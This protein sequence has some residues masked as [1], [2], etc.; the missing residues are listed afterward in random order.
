MNYFPRLDRWF[1]ISGYYDHHK[2]KTMS[3]L[4]KSELTDFEME[5]FAREFAKLICRIRCNGSF[6]FGNPEVDL[7]TKF[8]NAIDGIEVL[9]DE[10]KKC[11]ADIKFFYGMVSQVRYDKTNDY[12]ASIDRELFNGYFGEIMFYIVREQYLCDEKIMIEPVVPKAYSKQSG[13][14]YIEIRKTRQNGD[15]YFIVGE[16]KTSKNTIGD[17]PNDIIHSLKN[18]SIHLFNS[19]VN[20]F[21]ERAKASDDENLKYFVDRIPM[22][23][24]NNSPEKK[25]AGVINYGSNNKHRDSVFQ[26]FYTECAGHVNELLDCRR[27]K[28]IGIKDIENIKE[29]VLDCIWTTL[30][31]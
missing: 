26:N 10:E 25:F 24:F 7:C 19:E 4:L 14:D 29:R 3:L 9:S 27:I 30:L 6:P 13:L 16:V 23:F 31:I 8:Q 18:R 11:L 17:Y 28:L 1:N 20:A 12:I 21:K 22:Y 15:Y 2:C 5:S